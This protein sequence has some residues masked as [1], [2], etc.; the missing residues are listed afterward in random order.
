ME[1]EERVRIALPIREGESYADSVQIDAVSGI[2]SFARTE[3][4]GFYAVHRRTRS[5][6]EHSELKAVNVNP[7]EGD[8]RQLDVTEIMDILRPVRQPL[9]TLSSFGSASDFSGSQSVSDW[10]L[11]AVILFLLAEMFL[12]G[13]MVPPLGR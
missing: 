2:A 11:Y 7:L 3:R 8:I 5:G 6:A 9:E 10:L 4:P 13:R 12:A 1:Y